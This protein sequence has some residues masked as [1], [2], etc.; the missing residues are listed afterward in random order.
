MLGDR[1]RALT[2]GFDGYLSKPIEFATFAD[3][4]AALLR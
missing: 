3:T 1:E 4:V 2:A